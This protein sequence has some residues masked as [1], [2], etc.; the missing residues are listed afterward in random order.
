MTLPET[1][2]AV[3][4]RDLKGPEA[5]HVESRPVPHPVAGEVLIAVRAAGVNYADVMQTR[6][7]YVGG[8][9]APYVPGLEAAGEVVAAG[10]GAQIPVGARVLGGGAGAFAEYVAWPASGLT[11]LPDSWSYGQGAA[12]FVQW[13]TA[14]GCLRT[15]GR[16][17][18]GEHVLVHAAAGGVG[19]AAV[20]LAKHFGAR[21]IATASTQAKLERAAR[22]GADV[23]VNYTEEDFVDA[24]KDATDGRGADLVLEMVGGETFEK[25]FEAVRPYGRVVVYGSASAQKASIDNVTLIFRPVEV[26]GYHLNV[27][28]RKRPDLFAAEV[29]EV[30]ALIQAGVIQPEEPTLYPFAQAAEALA[31]LEARQTT[32]KLALVPGE[33][34]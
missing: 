14:H 24:V 8:P 3:V 33:V 4:V 32:G 12:F 26:L 15:I 10:E 19:T 9:E 17:K 25:N 22:F 23:L 29:R 6:G 21:V 11:Q 2:R 16:L 18:R 1:M 34:G 30:Q 7:L 5:A 13:F 31:A 27:L 28:S 20:R